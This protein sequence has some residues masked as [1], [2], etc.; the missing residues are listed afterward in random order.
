MIACKVVSVVFFIWLITRVVFCEFYT[1]RVWYTSTVPLFRHLLFQYQV[2]PHT[3]TV[4]RPSQASVFNTSCLSTKSSPTLGLSYALRRLSS[5]DSNS[6]STRSSSTPGLSYVR[7]RLHMVVRRSIPYIP[8]GGLRKI[9][10]V[11][12]VQPQVPYSR[13]GS[14]L[15]C[16]IIF[17]RHAESVV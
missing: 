1:F 13:E 3:W 14:R 8:F 9:A 5:T 6:L 2:F 10:G 12:S 11:Q 7:R 17:F 4:L 15:V 16:D